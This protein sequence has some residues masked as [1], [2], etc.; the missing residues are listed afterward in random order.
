MKDVGKFVAVWLLGAAIPAAAKA[1][2]V[3]N[4]VE[5]GADVVASY[6]GSIDTH[7]L[8]FVG[9]DL[10]ETVIVEPGPFPSNLLPSSPEPSDHQVLATYGEVAAMPGEIKNSSDQAH[11]PSHPPRAQ[12]VADTIAAL[13]EAKE[14]RPL[15]TVVMP[16]GLDFGVA[17]LNE[18]VAPIQNGLLGAMG[19]S[20]II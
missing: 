4:I 15:R 8:T 12:L 19:M 20:S 6:S 14:R 2:I 7:G 13:V 5:V 16:E 1:S 10:M 11:S 9:N 3:L 17:R 18:A